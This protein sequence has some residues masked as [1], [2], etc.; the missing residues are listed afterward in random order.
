[1]NI[2]SKLLLLVSASLIVST[3]VLGI[4]SYTFSKNQLTELGETSLKNNTN[5]IVK[6]I[7]SLDKKVNKGEL[8]LDEAKKIVISEFLGEKDSNGK[9][10]INKNI[11][12]GDNGYA[13]IISKDGT[14]L[15]HPSSEGENIWKDKDA[16][17]HLVGKEIVKSTITGDGFARYQWALPNNP[18]ETGQKI[19]YSKQA[20]WGWIVSTG[21]YAQDFNKSAT[22]ILYNTLIVFG[23][24]LVL[25]I[26]VAWF[27]ANKISKQ[28]NLVKNQLSN[29]AEGDFSAEPVIVNSSDETKSLADSLNKMSTNLKELLNTV[30]TASNELS[31]ASQETATSTEELVSATKNISNSI[32]DVS[33]GAKL[34]SQHTNTAIASLEKLYELIEQARNK[35]T[36][37]SSNSTTTLSSAEKGMH[38]VKKLI[39]QISIIKDQTTHTEE[40]IGLLESYTR[41]IQVIANTITDIAEQT[42]LLALNASIEAARAGEAGKGFAVVADEVRKLAEETNEGAKQV[43]NLT[44]K[45]SEASK[46]SSVSMTKNKEVV[47]EGVTSVEETGSSLEEILSAVQHTVKD[48]EALSNLANAEFNV[49]EELVGIITELQ[50]IMNKTTDNA[51]EVTASSEETLASIQDVSAVSEETSAMANQLNSSI[52]KFKL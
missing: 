3:G 4:T 46:Q 50:E 49:A 35:A 10:T 43:T 16:N 52:N 18:D 39:K 24:M 15:A 23:I 28:L 2:K 12:L 30:Y 13:F 8:T 51:V 38:N 5:M 29:M 14:L 45:I 7:D 47:N 6:E 25:V 41:E 44:A 34:G 20:K 36:N 21:S 37:S 17:G 48:I 9:R 33:E 11:D 27:F 31:D 40:V 26:F 19:V 32:A 22:V 1:M 42:N